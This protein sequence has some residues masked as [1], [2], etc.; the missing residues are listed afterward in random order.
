[1]WRTP[2]G[3]GFIMLAV[4]TACYGFASN[5]QGNI[6]TNYLEEVLKFSGPQFGYFTA[7]REVGGLVL[8]FL[9]ALLYRISLQR[10]TAGAL[11]VLGL[12]YMFFTVATDFVSLIPWVLLTSFGLHTILQTQYSLGLSLT[13][14]DKSGT[15][16]GKIASFG[17]A[18]TLVAYVM[19]FFLF[20][21]KWLSFKPTFIILGAVAMLGAVA[22]F[23]FPHLHEGEPRKV[24]PK[25][26]RIV[27]RREYKYYYWLNLLDGGRQQIFFSF[28]L[29]VLVKHFGFQV[30]QVSLLLIVVTFFSMVSSAW[31]GRFI[32]RQGERRSLS[33]I[34]VLYIVA[35]GGY[36]LSGN[37]WLACFFYLIYAVISPFSFVGAAVYLRKIAVPQDIPSSLS[38]GV[39]LLHATAV[40]VPVAAGYILNFTGYRV[41]FFIA[42]GFALANFFVTLGL[43]PVKQRC[44][45]RV[46]LD[47]AALAAATREDVAGAELRH[48]AGD[49]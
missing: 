21:F 7:I 20:Q 44:A 5:A 48:T 23:R 24:A 37:V 46:A 33:Y 45:A 12:G 9:T 17:Q 15:V 2:V 39:T 26:E 10:V 32:D 25:R 1:M 49:V 4:M 40:V 6:V 36:A 11:V 14:Q 18:G 41:P 35:L 19:V 34:N 3:R 29:Y 42:C 31:I 28:G 8:I 47:E 27:F 30:P 22:I 43:D 13:T 16:L 38:M